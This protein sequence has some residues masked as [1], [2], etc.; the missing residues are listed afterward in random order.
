MLPLAPS[1]LPSVSHPQRASLMIDR[2]LRID[3]IYIM[4]LLGGRSAFFGVITPARGPIL[5]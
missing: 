2:L 1:V 4:L 3:T 5:V